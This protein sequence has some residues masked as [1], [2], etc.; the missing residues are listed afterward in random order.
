M[1]IRISNKQLN[2]ILLAGAKMSNICFKLSQRTS[3]L[4]VRDRICMQEC[5]EEWDSAY[6]IKRQVVVKKV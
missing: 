3:A 1:A 5:Q 6:P 2:A 4:T